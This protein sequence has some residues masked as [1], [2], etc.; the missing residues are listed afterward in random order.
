MASE[1][2]QGPER[3]DLSTNRAPKLDPIARESAGFAA[4]LTA[5]LRGSRNLTALP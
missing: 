1:A 4:S 3:G 5:V 2:Q